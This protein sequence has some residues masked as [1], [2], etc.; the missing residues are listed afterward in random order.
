MGILGN[1]GL[2]AVSIGL[3]DGGGDA[4]LDAGEIVERV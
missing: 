1:V 4:L 3:A 2:W